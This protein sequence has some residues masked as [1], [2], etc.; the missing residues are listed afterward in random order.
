MN[1]K[2]NKNSI[3]KIYLIYFISMFLFVLIRILVAENLLRFTNNSVLQ[4]IIFSTITQI[5]LMLILP[6][7]L[8]Y[9]LIKEKPKAVFKLCNFKKPKLD[10]VLIS[11]LFGL[12]VFV[13]NIVIS[14]FFNGVLG[15]WGY[16]SAVVH[17]PAD[18]TAL[19]F[20][21]DILLVAIL[22]AVCEEFMHRGIILQGSK[23]LGY[24]KAIFYSAILFGLIHLNIEQF[25][26]A[27][28]LGVV[29]AIITIATKNIWPAI[30]VHFVNN[31][32]VVYL[33]G[34]N[35]FGWWGN[36]YT[37]VISGFMENLNVLVFINVILIVFLLVVAIMAYLTYLLYKRTVVKELENKIFNITNK[38]TSITFDNA[39]QVEDSEVEKIIKQSD[40]NLDYSSMRSI[41]D[42]VLPKEREVHK[43]TLKD[44]V[45]LYASV[46]LGLLTTIFTFIWGLF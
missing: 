4:S 30:I 7:F 38:Q 41:I 31:A 44:K 12:A 33:R 10:I 2:T 26:Y 16:R 45:F 8:Y 20:I 6:L 43:A 46:F 37:S 32:I 36:N 22:P 39:Q 15:F 17:T 5:I 34:A 11:L 21:V 9:L 23:N 13:F 42:V 14:S 24:K 40:I 25:F 29:L 3:N 27:A 19:K 28:I 35:A 1:T 18:Y